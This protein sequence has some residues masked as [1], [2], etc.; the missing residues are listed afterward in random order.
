MRGTANYNLR[1]PTPIWIKNVGYLA[2]GLSVLA[3]IGLIIC[4][5]QLNKEKAGKTTPPPKK[6]PVSGTPVN[7]ETPE[8]EHSQTVVN[9]SFKKEPDGG[10]KKAE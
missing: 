1:V 9:R 3:I 4:V 8:S 2:I 7:S 6:D 10:Q 5:W